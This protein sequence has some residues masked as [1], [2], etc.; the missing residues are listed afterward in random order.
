MTKNVQN[1]SHF[2]QEFSH[3]EEKFIQENL[4]HGARID[5]HGL[6]NLLMEQM[7]QL[8]FLNLLQSQTSRK[9]SFKTNNSEKIIPSLSGSFDPQSQI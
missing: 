7:N 9:I 4:S 6:Q 3:D 8:A 1:I 5:I 2:L